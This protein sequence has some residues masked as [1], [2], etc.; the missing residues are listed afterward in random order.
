MKSAI[1]I[2]E[3]INQ[4]LLDTPINSRKELLELGYITEDDTPVCRSGSDSQQTLPFKR[5]Y[6]PKAFTGILEPK[7][8]VDHTH[9]ALQILLPGAGTTFSTAE[10]L[11]D[12]A[13]TFHGKKSKNRGRK[14][15]SDANPLDE[16]MF[17]GNKFRV[18]SFPTDLPLNGM[19]SEAPF[20]FGSERGLMAVVRHVHLV[21][22]KLYPDLPVFVGGRSQGGITSILYAQHYDDFAGAFAINPP[23]PDKQLFDYTVEYLES[24]AETL[25]ELLHAPGVSLHQQ[26][27]DAYKT[28][29]PSFNYPER[30]SLS[31]ILIL[32]SSGDTFNLFPKYGD[33]LQAFGNQSELHQVHILDA[34]HNLWDRRAADMY[35]RVMH[36]Q[37]HFML[38]QISPDSTF[39]K[40]AQHEPKESVMVKASKVA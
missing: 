5:L 27:W 24:K 2:L 3:T 29:T 16:L 26:S 39:E 14:R 15:E 32:V 35:H 31:P 25:S 9:C 12:A 21:L 36:L 10:T 18:A 23:H 1:E 11:C 17:N 4:Q 8:A 37:A 38:G 40:N 19:G 34:G 13:G 20:E 33:E 30:T 22:S 7:K 28:F 6:L